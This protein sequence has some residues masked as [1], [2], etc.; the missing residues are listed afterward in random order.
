MNWAAAGTI[1]TFTLA[2]IGAIRYVLKRIRGRK[3]ITYELLD[4]VPFL[5]NLPAVKSAGLS[6]IYNGGK[7]ENPHLLQ[8]QLTSK[9]Y[10]DISSPAFDQHRPLCI[11]VGVPIVA[12]LETR[13]D[14]DQGPF[15]KITTTGTTLQIWPDKIRHRQ[16][17][18][19][20]ILTDDPGA[21]LTCSSNPILNYDLREGVSYQARQIRNTNIKKIIAW[22]VVIFVVLLLIANP[23]GVTDFL[24]GVGNS[25]A[26]FFTS[27]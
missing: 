24:K 21:H 8:V 4:S 16:G 27:L 10:R 9:S 25:L 15:P 1:L 20:S 22:V 23:A 18:R 17:M 7:L 6:V 14:P 5:R 11:D 3:V 13:Y 12:L 26:N 2:F 19:F